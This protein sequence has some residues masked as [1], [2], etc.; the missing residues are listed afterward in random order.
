MN[1]RFCSYLSRKLFHGFYSCVSKARCVY[2]YACTARRPPA[3]FCSVRPV[4]SS[5]VLCPLTKCPQRWLYGVRLPRTIGCG[6]ESQS[7]RTHSK[8]GGM[9]KYSCAELW[10][11]KNHKELRFV[12]SDMKVFCHYAESITVYGKKH[13]RQFRIT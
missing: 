12:I 11:H 5:H 3:S 13:C 10:V 2:I 1:S 6:F 4:T 7:R 8:A 9:Q